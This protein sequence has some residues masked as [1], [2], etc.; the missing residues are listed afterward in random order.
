MKTVILGAGPAGL[1]AAWKLA[2]QG[3]EALVLEKTDRVGG[4]CR[5][6]SH[7]DYIFDLGGHRFFTKFDEVQ[8]LWEA[9]LGEE[10]LLR[11][12]TSRIYY[13]GVFF[14]Y[15]LRATN[16]LRGLGPI[17]SVRC[18]L[19]YARARGRKRQ[20]ER[21]F[22]EWVSNRFGDRL[23][24]IFFRTY[25]E[26]VWGIPTSEIGAEWASQRIK[27]LELSTAVKDALLRGISRPG[28]DASGKVVT[29][30]IE[31]FHYPRYGPGQMYDAMAAQTVERGGTLAM[32]H[33]VIRLEREEG[34]VNRVIA[35]LPDGTEVSFE[36]DFVLSSMPLTLLMQALSPLPPD[37]VIQAARALQFR[38]LLTVDL[39]VDHPD[40]FDD[41]WIYIHDPTLQVGRVQNFKNWSPDMVPDPSTTSLG[42]EYFCWDTDDLWKMDDA[43]LVE[44]ATK[45]ARATGLMKGAPVLWGVVNRVPKAYP[46]YRTGYEVHLQV[47]QEFMESMENLQVMGRYGMFKYNNADHSILTALLCVENLLGANHN[48]WAVNTDSEYQEIRTG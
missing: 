48:V 8:A 30:L 33:K 21:T 39:I 11:P 10:F 3:E 27:N 29:S 45:E 2:G 24:E 43:A 38:N 20:S 26:K 36:A 46:V 17:E 16:A 25:T 22:E 15:P 37:E 31:E 40:L 14:D 32:E 19:S 6:V 7:K 28:R 18:M 44:L 47:L 13:K 9:V 35:E 1:S 34:R 5:T 23:F 12:R 42:L 4:I 41:T